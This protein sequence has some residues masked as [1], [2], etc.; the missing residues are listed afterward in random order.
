MNTFDFRSELL[1]KGIDLSVKQLEQF[2]TYFELLVLWNG[3]MNLTAITEKEE[4]FRKHFFDSITPAFY[5]SFTE[6]KTLCDVGSGAGFPGVP[7]KIIFPHVH[8]TLVDSLAK[9]IGFLKEVIQTLGLDEIEAKHERVED[10]AMKKEYRESYDVVV[11]RAVANL[12]VLS[13]YCLPLV[14]TNGSFLALKGGK[15]KEEVA[16]SHHAITFLGG[17]VKQVFDFVLPE[18][19]AERSIIEIHKIKRTPQNYP[20]KA[21]VASKSPL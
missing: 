18:D 10:F 7:L 11:A 3:R 14:R 2:N 21:V 16:S 8:V 15:G 6:I 9:R 1:K 13:E 12:S 20:R 4:V 17:E 5:F 19:D